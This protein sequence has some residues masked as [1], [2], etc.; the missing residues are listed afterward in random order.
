ME[1]NNLPKIF[2]TINWPTFLS[3]LPSCLSGYRATDF[4]GTHALK[5]MGV[6][7]LTPGVVWTSSAKV[8]FTWVKV[9]EDRDERK[10]R[11]KAR[12]VSFRRCLLQ[13]RQLRYL[14]YF[15]F[16]IGN[17]IEKHKGSFTNLT[18]RKKWTFKGKLQWI[19][20]LLCSDGCFSSFRDYKFS[21][22]YL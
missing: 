10:K 22:E 5:N 11:K 17:I 7:R 14:C 21:N 19:H 18:L 9:K 3:F 4:W 1:Q 16:T 12:F 20:Y 13:T 15:I 2:H 8:R 6:L